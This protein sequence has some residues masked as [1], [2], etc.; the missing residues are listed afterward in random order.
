M[1]LQN[2]NSNPVYTIDEIQHFYKTCF[3]HGQLILSFILRDK[4]KYIQAKNEDVL[5]SHLTSNMARFNNESYRMYATIKH[6]FNNGKDIE[7]VS[8]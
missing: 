3:E 5:W 4:E 6:S 2:T 1:N 7:G 8:L